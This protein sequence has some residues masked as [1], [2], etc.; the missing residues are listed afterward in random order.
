MAQYAPAAAL[1]VGKMMFSSMVALW[2][3]DPAHPQY[4]NLDR[5][6]F[7]VSRLN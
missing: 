1:L 4:H 7:L 3:G 2:L 6:L 5:F